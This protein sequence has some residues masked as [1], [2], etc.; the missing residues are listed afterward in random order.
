MREFV[1]SMFEVVNTLFQLG[2]IP[3][4]WLLKCALSKSVNELLV[5]DI[6][7]DFLRENI[8]SENISL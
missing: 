6:S 3:C 2:F 5:C 8:K 4:V 7:E 1:V